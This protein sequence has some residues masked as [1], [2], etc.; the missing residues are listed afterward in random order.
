MFA[1]LSGATGTQLPE[2]FADIKRQLVAANRE[3]LAASWTRLLGRLAEEN[4]TV[5]KDGPGVIPQI[6]FS[7]LSNPSSRFADE[8][9]KRGVVV[10]RGVVPEEEARA[11]KAEIEDYVKTNPWTK[12][13]TQCCWIRNANR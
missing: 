7:D 11:Y 1:S 4:C 13:K 9:K 10:I 3:S 5:K 6:D 2:K 8:V 12:G